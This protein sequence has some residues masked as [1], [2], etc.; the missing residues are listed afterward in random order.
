MLCGTVNI[1]HDIF[2]N[3][4]EHTKHSVQY[5]E[6]H[7]TLLWISIMLCNAEEGQVYLSE[8]LIGSIKHTSVCEK[9]M[10]NLK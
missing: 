10:L 2:P 7:K 4:Y 3:Q 8:H 1:P 6:S 9:K 5:C